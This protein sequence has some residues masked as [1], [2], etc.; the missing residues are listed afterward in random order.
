MTDPDFT[1]RFPDYFDSVE[2]EITAKGYF[3]DLMVEAKGGVYR[4]VFY[5]QTRFGQEVRDR[6]E[7]GDLCY[8]EANLVLLATVDR[9]H[10][11]A[12]VAWLARHDFTG[13]GAE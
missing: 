6:L 11:E 1:V 3:A 5:D 12:A 13:L 10:I 9:V 2:A 8:V 4:P 7:A